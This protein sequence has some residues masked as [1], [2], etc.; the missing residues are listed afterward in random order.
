MQAQGNDY[1]YFDFLDSQKPEIDFSQLSKA[2]SNRRFGVGSDG[3]VLLESSREN[4][5]RMT[6]YNADGSEGKMCGSALRCLI[7]YLH[8]KKGKKKFAVETKSGIRSGEVL[9]KNLIKV[10]MGIPFFQNPQPVIVKSFEGFL[11][12]TGN[13]HLVIYTD[14][15]SEEIARNYGAIIQSSADYLHEVNIDFVKKINEKKIILSFWE[16]GSGETL[17]C[18]T[19]ITAA[20]FLGKQKFSLNSS[21]EAVVPGGKVE[22]TSNADEIFITGEVGYV[23]E[24]SWVK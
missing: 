19:G 1:L 3:I 11:V 15:F 7:W 23:F 10:N 16:R 4:D 22:V 8:Q 17:S 13:Q 24:G 18:G 12:N 2:V 9:D 6:I 21:I 5:A 20:F 14:Q